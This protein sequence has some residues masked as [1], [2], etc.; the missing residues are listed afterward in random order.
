MAIAGFAALLG[1]GLILGAQ[2][3]GP[4]A[5]APYAIVIF[6]VQV[7]FVLAWTMAMRPPAPA[8]VAGVGAGRRGAVADYTAV[9]TET[10]RLLPLLYVPPIGFVLV[11]IGQFALRGRPAAG[12]ATRSAPRC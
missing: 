1:A 9:T 2:T 6:G 7:L 11:V 4:D 3:S 12:H 5:R 8:L 10:P